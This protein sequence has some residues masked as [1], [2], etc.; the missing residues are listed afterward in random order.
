VGAGHAGGAVRGR[1]APDSGDHARATRALGRRRET[2]E[3]LRVDPRVALVVIGKGVAFTAHSRAMVI[4]EELEA[5]DTVVAVELTVERVQ[6]HLA[7]ERTE[8]L[9]GARWRWCNEHDGEMED[10][11][12]A[13][14]EGL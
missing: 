4:A 3:R 10:R 14:L 7:D 8:M 2:L 6:D 11:I 13:E 12:V 5:T 9:D 1:P